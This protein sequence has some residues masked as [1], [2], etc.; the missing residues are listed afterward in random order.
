MFKKIDIKNI[1]VGDVVE[2]RLGFEG[3]HLFFKISEITK[4]MDTRVWGPKKDS[5]NKEK[6]FIKPFKKESNIWVNSE[7]IVG[8]WR[9]VSSLKSWLNTTV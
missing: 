8:F 2:Y 4:R 7:S 5:Y 3:K 6:A 1:K 9:K